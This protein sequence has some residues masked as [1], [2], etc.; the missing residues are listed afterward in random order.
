[1]PEDTFTS[2][3]IPQCHDRSR[4]LM[5]AIGNLLDA[6]CYGD[7]WVIAEKLKGLCANLRDRES[8]S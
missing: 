1:M 4:F 6:R 7:A 8:E 3:T 2:L 5:N